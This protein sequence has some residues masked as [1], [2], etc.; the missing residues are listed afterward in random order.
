M[1]YRNWENLSRK[2]SRGSFPFFGTR[3]SSFRRTTFKPTGHLRILKGN[4][5]PEGAVAKIT[6][7]EGLL[8]SGTAKIYNG[9]YEANDGIANGEVKE[10]DVVVIRYEGPKGGPGMPE[11]L[12]PTSAIMG[13]GLGRKWP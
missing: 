6:G 10:G 12:K 13:R 11:M 1:P 8:F 4:L 9:E 3:D 2:F 7:K 5:A